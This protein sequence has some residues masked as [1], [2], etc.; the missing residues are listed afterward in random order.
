MKTEYTSRELRRLP[1]VTYDTLRTWAGRRNTDEESDAGLRRS[2]YKGNSKHQPVLLSPVRKPGATRCWIYGGDAVERIWQIR[3]LQMLGYKN[4]QIEEIFAAPDQESGEAIWKSLD[5]K[6]N[7][8]RWKIQHLSMAQRFA[9][10]LRSARKLPYFPHEEGTDDIDRYLEVLPVDPKAASS[11]YEAGSKEL[12]KAHGIDKD[13]VTA[14]FSSQNLS[15]F[16]KRFYLSVQKLWLLQAPADSEEVYSLIDTFYTKVYEKH[17]NGLRQLHAA[18]TLLAKQGD[19][20]RRFDG[21]YGIGFSA[22]LAEGIFIYCF[23]Q[24]RIQ[25]PEDENPQSLS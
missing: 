6:I 4:G 3:M 1:G 18:G 14:Q 7:D 17:E 15:D 16:R 9:E 25:L 8:L 20:G 23:I 12:L 19:I 13:A 10:T 2:M 21:T 11:G 24:D 22:F 5:E